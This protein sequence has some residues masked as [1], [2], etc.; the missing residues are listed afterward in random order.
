M[1]SLLPKE[2][3]T[4]FS[5]VTKFRYS[6]NINLV[7]N[8]GIIAPARRPFPMHFGAFRQLFSVKEA[9]KNGKKK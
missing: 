4:I 3:G 7:S 5:P 1:E 2:G 6:P 9:G 8:M